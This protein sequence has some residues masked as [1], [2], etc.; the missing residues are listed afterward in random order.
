MAELFRLQQVAEL[1]EAEQRY[2]LRPAGKARQA[3]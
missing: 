1:L 3:G 2:L